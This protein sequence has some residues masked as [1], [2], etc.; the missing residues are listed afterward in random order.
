[1]KQSIGILLALGLAGAGYWMG[2]QTVAV[3]PQV[4]DAPVE[5][6]AAATSVPCTR[7]PLLQSECDALRAQLGS[8]AVAASAES[9]PVEVAEAAAEEPE[10]EAVDE[11]VM[12]QRR[13][14]DEQIEAA[15]RERHEKRIAFLKDVDTSLLSEEE[16]A[17]HAEFVALT[18]EIEQLRLEAEAMEAMATEEEEMPIW[19]TYREKRW[20]QRNLRE[21]EY[22]VLVSA[23]ATSMGLSREESAGLPELLREI[24]DHTEM[25]SSG[26]HVTIRHE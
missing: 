24:Q 7:C 16:R 6:V 23:V 21:A 22:A 2:R 26:I 9:A 11:E 8:T 14:V 17:I 1:M 18:E 25:G 15:R 5:A 20:K 10:A 12:A 4:A 19:R 13:M 3:A